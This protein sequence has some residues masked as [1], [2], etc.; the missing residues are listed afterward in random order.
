MLPR[1]FQQ[2]PHCH[3][4]LLH[5]LAWQTLTGII[6]STDVDQQQSLPLGTGWAAYGSGWS[7]PS[8]AVVEGLSADRYPQ[9]GLELRGPVPFRQG[10]EL[11]HLIFV[12]SRF[13]SCSL[14]WGTAPGLA[15]QNASLPQKECPGRTPQIVVGFNQKPTC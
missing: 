10:T 7:P 15:S 14:S 2:L 12:F 4:Q 6:F 13:S 8:W 9:S 5:P 11:K 1:L 3:C